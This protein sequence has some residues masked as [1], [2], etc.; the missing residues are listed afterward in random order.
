MSL[1]DVMHLGRDRVILKDLRFPAVP[2][3]EEAAVV[4]FQ[5]VKELTDAAEDVV[6]DYV[7]VSPPGAS[8]QQVLALIARRELI[9]T[10]QAMCQAAG[11]K[12][13]ALTPRPFGVA[14]SVRKATAATPPDDP[15]GAT[16]AEG[17]RMIQAAAADL[18]AVVAGLHRHLPR[19]EVTT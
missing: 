3:G 8:E 2:A 12:L 5:A 18:A 1:I 15:E 13:A 6:I 4:R 17:R 11:L 9:V 14:A 19:I 16:A 7:G 10:Y